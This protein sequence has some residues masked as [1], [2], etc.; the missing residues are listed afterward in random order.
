MTDEMGSA[1]V[2]GRVAER[3][4][5]VSLSDIGFAAFGGLDW[6]SDVYRFGMCLVPACIN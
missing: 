2:A 4:G 5:G 6:F 1:R 3:T